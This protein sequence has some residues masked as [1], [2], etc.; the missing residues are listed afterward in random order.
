MKGA[1]ERP[2][3]TDSALIIIDIQEALFS[4][5]KKEV[6]DLVLK[7]TLALIEAS[8][9][10]EIPVLITEQYPK[11]LGMTLPAI[12]KSLGDR[13]RPREKLSFSIMGEAEIRNA[14]SL[15]G[16]RHLLICGIETHVCVLQSVYDLLESGYIPHVIVDAV[17]SRKKLDWEMG[18][19]SARDAGAILTTAEA[20]LFLLLERAGT[21]EFKA[22]SKLVK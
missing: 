15:L 20:A 17:S 4:A 21:Q 13:Y 9:T 2:T 5:M 12:I 11:G 18:L 1:I 14:V 16:K 22:I 3:K 6:A 8:K 10:F 19:E 7:N